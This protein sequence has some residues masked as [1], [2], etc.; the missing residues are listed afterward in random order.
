MGYFT[1]KV[2]TQEIKTQLNWIEEKSVMKD[3]NIIVLTNDYVE[4]ELLIFDMKYGAKWNEGEHWSISGKII[5]FTSNMP[6]DLT[7][8]IINL[9]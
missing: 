4:D 9:G 1:N 7:F 6:S 5:T 8:R 2:I 3:K